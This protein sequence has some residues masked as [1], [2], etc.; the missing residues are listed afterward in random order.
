MELCAKTHAD[1][2]LMDVVMGIG[3]DGL[4]ADHSVSHLCN[5]FVMGYHYNRLAEFLS[6]D[7]QQAENVL[8]CLAVKVSGRLVR[9]DDRRFCG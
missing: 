1:L 8:R 4:D 6:G 9:K 2:V 3:M 5:R 7:F